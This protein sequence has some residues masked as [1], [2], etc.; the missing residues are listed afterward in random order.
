MLTGLVTMI[1][2][3]NYRFE[4]IMRVVSLV[5][6]MYFI[7]YSIMVFITITSL[8]IDETINA[9]SVYT[10][11]EAAYYAPLWQDEITRLGLLEDSFRIQ[12]AYDDD[13]GNYIAVTH[14]KTDE[15][16]LSHAKQ[17]SLSYMDLFSDNP[18]NLV[19]YKR[20]LQQYGHASQPSEKLGHFYLK[21][22]VVFTIIGIF[23][24]L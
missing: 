6:N 20:D 11:E 3:R 21:S 8:V 1:G 24:F 9:A 19:R 16:L 10:A 17:I 7:P 23:L 4:T 13:V 15:M 2:L 12:S 18:E 14:V 22:S 5:S